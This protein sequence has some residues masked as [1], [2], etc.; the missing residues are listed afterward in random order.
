[1]GKEVFIGIG[2]NPD[3]PDLP[4]GLGM[5]L[6]QEPKALQA[7]GN[8]SHSE[9]EALINYIQSSTTGDDA[10]NRIMESISRLKNGPGDSFF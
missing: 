2:H 5:Q 1:M 6:A 9:K 4:M 8:L 10:K 3:G 7:Y